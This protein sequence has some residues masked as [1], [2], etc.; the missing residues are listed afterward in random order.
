ME[1]IAKAC[2]APDYPAEPVVVVA[3]N[4]DAKGLETARRLGITTCS[5]PRSGYDSR[6]DHE[7]AIADAIEN[8]NAD[9]VCLAGFMR[10]LSDAFVKRFE[11]RLINIHPSL[12]PLY[13]GLDTHARAL[14]DGVKVHG[15]TVHFVNAEMDGGAIIAQA[16]V[17]VLPGDGEAQLAARVLKMEHVLYPRVV[18]LIA[19][20]QVYLESGKVVLKPEAA[21]DRSGYLIS[22]HT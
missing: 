21:A 1:A 22:V 7:H 20:D 5:F 16:A 12:L 18:E 3:D 6:Q 9:I 13:K 14:E 15:C 2:E 10:I 8:A 17:P 11:G 4:H 19:R